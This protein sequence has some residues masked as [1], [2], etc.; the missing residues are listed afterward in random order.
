MLFTSYIAHEELDN[1]SDGNQDSDIEDDMSGHENG[2]D[3]GADDDSDVGKAVVEAERWTLS[4]EDE[5]DEQSR[6]RSRSIGVEDNGEG[7][8]SLIKPFDGNNTR[9]GSHREGV[10]AVLGKSVE[11]SA[12]IGAISINRAAETNRD[13]PVHRKSPSIHISLCC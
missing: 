4:S 2:A 8:S 6:G 11:E 9:T 12:G 10:S 3:L 5:D 1:A 13:A 7:T